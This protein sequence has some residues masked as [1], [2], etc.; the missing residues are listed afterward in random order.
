MAEW[1]TFFWGGK[2]MSCHSFLHAARCGNTVIGV[3]MRGSGSMELFF[4]RPAG[5]AGAGSDG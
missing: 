5:K 1:Q 3:Y 2:G 4:V